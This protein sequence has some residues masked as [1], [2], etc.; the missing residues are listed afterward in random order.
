MRWPVLCCVKMSSFT[1]TSCQIPRAK[2]QMGVNSQSQMLSSRPTSLAGA[3]ITLT[4]W[5]LYHSTHLGFWGRPFFTSLEWSVCVAVWLVSLKDLPVLN[6]LVLRLWGT[7][8]R[9]WLF[10][11]IQRRSDL[12]FNSYF[13]DE[14]V[15]KVNVQVFKCEHTGQRDGRNCKNTVATVFHSCESETHD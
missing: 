7:Y 14:A 15:F 5:A 6:F 2:I 4:C 9:A 10:T 11:W 12:L 13:T 8:H 1:P 3:I